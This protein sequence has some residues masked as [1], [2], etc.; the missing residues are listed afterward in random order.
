M[1]GS[2]QVNGVMIAF[3]ATLAVNTRIKVFTFCVESFMEQKNPIILFDGFCNLCHST[4]NWLIR[5]D[6]KGH[7]RFASLQS[8]FAQEKLKNLGI[9]LP[10]A[11]TV[12]LIDE[13]GVHVRSNAALL[14]L[15]HLGLPYSLAMLAT[16]LPRFFRDG[17]YNWIAR[18]RYRWF[19]VQAQ[20]LTPTP[21][22]RRRFL[23]E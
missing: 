1:V 21:E 18:N 23:D 7:L 12:I 9:D 6:R 2:H 15:K 20:C 14:I 16:L 11:K 8:K 13:R 4:V 17:V 22:L 3:S 19:G 10:Q 5:T